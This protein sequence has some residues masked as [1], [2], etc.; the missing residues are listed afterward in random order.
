[1]FHH[2]CG[3]AGSS[4]A[5][6]Y[7]NYLNELYVLPPSRYL[8]LLCTLE[9]KCHELRF[10]IA[11]ETQKILFVCVFAAVH[12]KNGKL[13]IIWISLILRI[14]IMFVELF[15][16][17]LL[18]LTNSYFQFITGS[19]VSWQILNQLTQSCFSSRLRANDCHK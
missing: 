7:Y 2:Q 16:S 18:N 10:F 9:H 1:M 19:V 15:I 5:S 14:C 17:I 8:F 4:L 6:L 11:K 3:L 12:S 13:Y